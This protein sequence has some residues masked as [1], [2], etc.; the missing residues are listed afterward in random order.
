MTNKEEKSNFETS[1]TCSHIHS[2]SL[3]HSFSL[4]VFQD[5]LV[6]VLIILYLC[7]HIMDAHTPALVSHD[8]SA[9]ETIS[10]CLAPAEASIPV[11]QTPVKETK[12]SN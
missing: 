4:S 11:L 3:R 10:L 9:S 2:L 7:A 12:G 1:L 8:V 6:A 5:F